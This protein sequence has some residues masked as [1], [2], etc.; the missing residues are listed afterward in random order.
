MKTEISCKC[1]IVR[2]Q[3]FLFFVA[4]ATGNKKG[5]VINNQALANKPVIHF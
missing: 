5:E 4:L 2:T 3:S 1:L